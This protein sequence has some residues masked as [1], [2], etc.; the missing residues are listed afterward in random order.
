[1]TPT[2]S[3]NSWRSTASRKERGWGMR[4]SRWV[5][6]A[7]LICGFVSMLCWSAAALGE[8]LS[9]Q[10]SLL[11][12][13]PLVI[14]GAESL[15]GGQEAAEEAKRMS[16]EAVE[17]REVS[18]SAYEGMSAE[19]AEKVSAEAF[20]GLI[21]EPDG[22]G[23]PH[24]PAGVTGYLN[25]YTAELPVSGGQRGL[26]VS[27]VP[28]AFE[29]SSGSWSAVSLAISDTGGVFGAANPLVAVRA[30][31]QL[32]EGMQLSSLGVTVTPVDTQGS[33][34]GGSEGVVDGATVF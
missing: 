2:E 15:V 8:E 17:L 14:S 7:C 19:A 34:L 18:A 16:P 26:A 1:M 31:K 27:S 28:L 22:G 3:T 5:V 11:S 29:A 9:S 13:S 6:V 25:P 10:P 21:S 24:L 33:P 12:G 20:P 30:T 4:S 23:L 32:S